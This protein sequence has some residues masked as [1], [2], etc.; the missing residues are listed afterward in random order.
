MLSPKFPD[1]EKNTSMVVLMKVNKGKHWQGFEKRLNDAARA[2][3][4]VEVA[5]PTYLL[6]LS[7]SISDTMPVFWYQVDAFPY[8]L[9]GK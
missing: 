2:A 9:F 1:K 3:S 8:L 6:T 7:R 4:R 5:L